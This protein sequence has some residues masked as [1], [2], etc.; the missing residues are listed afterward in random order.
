MLSELTCQK[1][2]FTYL[3]NTS[4]TTI[5]ISDPRDNCTL[6]LEGIIKNSEISEAKKLN[7]L[8]SFVK[9]VLHI[10]GDFTTTGF[11]VEDVLSW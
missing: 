7:Y 8:N 3:L 1:V 10:K 4:F 11:T 2:S 6:L 5:I 9:F